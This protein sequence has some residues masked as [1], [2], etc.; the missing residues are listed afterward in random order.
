MAPRGDEIPK[1][2]PCFWYGTLMS[3]KV[4]KMVLGRELDVKPAV[5]QD[6]ERKRVK[7]CLYPGIQPKRGSQVDGV[8]AMVA[9]HEMGVLDRYE[10]DEYYRT[11][12]TIELET[13]GYFRASF[14]V[15]KE[16]LR[17]SLEG[18][19]NFDGLKEAGQFEDFLAEQRAYLMSDESGQMASVTRDA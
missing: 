6:Y 16:D 2:V 3:P 19:W 9:P 15:I 4:S 17:S 7:D 14:Y 8:M 5:L 18:D 1:E 11:T 13:G 10:G 12:D